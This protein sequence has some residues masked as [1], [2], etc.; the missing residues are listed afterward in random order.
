MA[1]IVSTRILRLLGISPRVAVASPMDPTPLDPWNGLFR[2]DPVTGDLQMW[3]NGAWTDQL[4]PGSITGIDGGGAWG[5]AGAPL[6]AYT[7]T[8][9]WLTFPTA[10]MTAYSAEPGGY[11]NQQFVYDEA[12]AAGG[13]QTLALTDLVKTWGAFY[14]KNLAEITSFS[15][16]LLAHVAG[17]FNL[18]HMP[19]LAAIDFS[20]L[21]TAGSIQLL[22]L[23]DLPTADFPA[24]TA[25]DYFVIDGASA[26]TSWDFSALASIGQTALTGGVVIQN[27]ALLPAIDFPVLT[28]VRGTG[29]TAFYL[30]TLPSVASISLP[31]LVEVAGDIIYWQHLA[32][33][34]SID[35]SSLT[36]AVG[37]YLIDIPALPALS[38]PAIVNISKGILL[39]NL[40]S[41]TSFSLGS[42]LLNISCNSS[43]N[44]TVTATPLDQSSVDGLL[45]Q[46]AALDGTGGTTSF[47][48]HTVNLADLCA[49]PSATG[50]AA[51]ATLEGRG[52]TVTVS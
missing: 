26:L 45:V 24:L 30:D 50:L 9:N 41:T 23:P 6:L 43:T 31:A 46:L 49:A 36:A 52:N 7:I 29:G 16:P 12:S 15:A 14:P 22:L 21:V 4:N 5:A 35:L 38:L 47:D 18:Y 37:L 25:T 3:K 11:G 51:K 33:V 40:S 28:Y 2:L 19:L 27:D 34:T 44:I 48:G 20:S 17:V 39:D 1:T 42:G 8:G 32:G 10:D 13:L